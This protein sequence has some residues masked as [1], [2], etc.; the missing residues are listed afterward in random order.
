MPKIFI[1]HGGM[2]V[3]AKWY[4][5]LLVDKEIWGTNEELH[6]TLLLKKPLLPS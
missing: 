4:D 2:D 6:S 5:Q 3:P 1:F